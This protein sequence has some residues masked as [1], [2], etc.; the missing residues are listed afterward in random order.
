MRPPSFR[1]FILTGF[2]IGYV[3]LRAVLNPSLAPKLPKE[4]TDIPFTQVMWALLTSFFPLAI[5]IVAVLGAIL[6]G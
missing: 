1:G 6:F 2:Y 3:I 4:Q 5:L